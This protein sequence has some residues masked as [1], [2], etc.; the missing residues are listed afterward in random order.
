MPLL[1]LYRAT[2]VS[3]REAKLIYAWSQMQVADE[4]KKRNK[5]ITLTFVDFIEAI[6]RLSELVCP[7][8]ASR[9]EEFFH[10]TNP[11]TSATPTWEY[12]ATV[13]EV[14]SVRTRRVSSEFTSVKTRALREKIEG[15]LEMMTTQLVWNYKVDVPFVFDPE[16]P[17]TGTGGVSSR[18]SSNPLMDALEACTGEKEVY[19]VHRRFHLAG[20]EKSVT[21]KI[22]A[23]GRAI[24]V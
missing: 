7:P 6:A 5:M 14:E 17:I 2:G 9:L 22:N 13:T 10:A 20:L 18:G 24:K 12:F 21:M 19:E 1:R 15:V 3:K 8:T 11:A 23:L 4:I 16:K